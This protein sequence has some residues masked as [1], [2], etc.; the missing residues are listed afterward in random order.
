MLASRQAEAQEA[1][2]NG[3]V[4]AVTPAAVMAC[5][6]KPGLNGAFADICAGQ[7]DEAGCA[8]VQETC[9]WGAQPDGGTAA[10]ARLR[11][12]EVPGGGTGSVLPARKARKAPAVVQFLPNATISPSLQARG[13]TDAFIRER[14]R[15]LFGRNVVGARPLL[16]HSWGDCPALYLRL[17]THTAAAALCCLPL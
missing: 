1:N 15:C 14:K 7:T 9:V 16:L 11:R 2:A 17:T 3:T 4:A 5:S 12:S 13:R 6:L 10:T 8:T